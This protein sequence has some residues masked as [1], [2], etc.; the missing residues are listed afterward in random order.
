MDT[1]KSPTHQCPGCNCELSF[2]ER[3]PNYYCKDCVKL[4]VDE[5][6]RRLLFGNMSF[7][8]GLFWA[9]AGEPKSGEQN[10]YRVKCLIK[11]RTVVVTEA[12]FGGVVAQPDDAA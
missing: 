9:F 12:R 4:T 2:W 11:G 7:S 10:C 5:N 6:G 3:Y 8:G 1:S